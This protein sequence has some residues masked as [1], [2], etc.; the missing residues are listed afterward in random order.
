MNDIYVT[1]EYVGQGDCIIIEW[2]YGERKRIGVVD[3]N[4][5]PGPNP[6]IQR[7][8]REGYSRIEFIVLS[9]PHNDHFSG[10]LPL[11]R[12]CREEK[13]QI[14]FFAYTTREV[15]SYLHS[16]ALSNN[17]QDR[18]A[19]VFREVREM[20]TSG[21]LESR[22]IATDQTKE[23][24]LGSGANMGFLAPSE[25]DR[26]AFAKTLYDKNG[27]VKEKP[28]ANLISSVVIIHTDE[29]YILLTSDAERNTLK[30]VGSGSLPQDN[31]P[32]LLG[33][34]PHHGAERNHYPAF[35]RRQE[36]KPGTPAPISVGPNN[37]GHPAENTI[38]GM[39]NLDFDVRTTG[40]VDKL[41]KMEISMDLDM[42][43]K[44]EHDSSM[45]SRDSSTSLVYK[46]D[47][48][49]EDLP[50]LRAIPK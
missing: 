19:N 4:S 41:E 29:W 43:S 37:Y 24:N 45:T 22:G 44:L 42:I 17:E 15:K 28:E 31:R 48:N 16:L 47:P 13:I 40:R 23:K 49:S 10:L 27:R 2:T 11:L 18:L 36:R 46:F 38:R 32:L 1:F 9:H 30:R 35:W 21:L 50:E 25:A 34:I 20:E 7:I 14:G 26:D 8:V 6:V 12:Y 33:Q 3:C 39:E 5:I